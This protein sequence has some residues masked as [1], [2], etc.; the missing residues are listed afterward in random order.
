MTMTLMVMQ[1]DPALNG[2]PWPK[3]GSMSSPNLRVAAEACEV[4]QP[5][6]FGDVGEPSA[7]ANWFEIDQN[8][9]FLLSSTCRVLE[10]NPAAEAAVIEGQFVS[11][12]RGV[13]AF[14]CERSNT[15]LTRA[16]AA[17]CDR[18]EQRRRDFFRGADLEWRAVETIR[19][20]GCDAAFVTFRPST[21]LVSGLSRLAE[22]FGLTPTESSVLSALVQGHAPKEIGRRLSISTATVRTHL[23]SIFA[24]LDV[25]GISGTLRL[26]VRLV[27]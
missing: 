4:S 22:A 6:L 25:H 18:Q 10:M 26:A 11:V 13:L 24:K 15:M 5:N 7:T 1:G 16:V 9:C 27:Q 19:A 3:N 23:R 12:R 8:A 21:P 14:A 2:R 17:V 20:P